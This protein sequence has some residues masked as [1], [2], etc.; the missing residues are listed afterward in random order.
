MWV[1]WGAENF[2]IHVN[3]WWTDVP[4]SMG[5]HRCI[6]CM[7]GWANRWPQGWEKGK[8][9]N[10]VKGWRER[11]KERVYCVHTAA[12]WEWADLPHGTSPASHTDSRWALPVS[13][14][15]GSAAKTRCCSSRSPHLHTHTKTTHNIRNSNQCIILFGWKRMLCKRT[16]ILKKKK[17]HTYIFY[18]STN[19]I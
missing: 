16:Y 8:R 19:L 17:I 5:E 13:P 11:M 12:S 1:R 18:I 10:E 15:P 3:G 9:T 4:V 7:S 14:S 2:P 6:T